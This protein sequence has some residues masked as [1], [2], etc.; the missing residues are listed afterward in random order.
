MTIEENREREAKTAIDSLQ[1]SDEDLLKEIFLQSNYDFAP[2][3]TDQIS[4]TIAYFSALLIKLSRQSEKSTRKIVKLT[5][6][7]LYLTWV[8][9]ILTAVLLFVAFF[10]VTKKSVVSCLNPNQK[11]EQIQQQK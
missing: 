4:R 8:L 5:R 3:K 10:E 1:K 7:L 11:S 6:Y 9:A 2:N